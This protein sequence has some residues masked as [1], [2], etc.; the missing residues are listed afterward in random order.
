M[1][2]VKTLRYY[3]KIGL[4]KPVYINEENGYRFY[5]ENQVSKVLLVCRLKEYGF[6][7]AEIMHMLSVH[8]MSVFIG[9]LK[10]RRSEIE[11]EIERLKAT[12][13]ELERH[14]DSLERTGDMMKFGNNY[15]I[16]VVEDTERRVISSRQRMSVDEF[17]KYYGEMYKRCETEKL[18]LTG[19]CLAVYHD[20]EFDRESSDIELLLGVD[21]N[22]KADKVMKG[23]K[24]AALTHYGA[25]SGLPQAYG[26]IVKWIAD[27]GY[28]IAGAPYEIYVK[29]WFNKVAVDEWETRV[30]FP[31]K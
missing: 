24:C 3:D 2:T 4:I 13:M 27:N 15:E 12:A 20:K 5:D 19:E 31:I 23:R 9:E 26:A 25:Y 16:E 17:G 6:S 8:D 28:E 21:E 10:E 14:I 7:L 1:V 29:T 18:V 30:L 22:S 11:L